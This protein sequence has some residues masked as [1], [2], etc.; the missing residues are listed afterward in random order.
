MEIIVIAD[1]SIAEI[2]E[3]LECVAEAQEFRGAS[4]EDILPKC[5]DYAEYLKSGWCYLWYDSDTL[6]P[7]GYTLFVFEKRKERFP[8][9]LMGGTRF[10]K[11]RHILKIRRAMLNVMRLEFKNQVRAYIDTDRIAKFAIANGFKKLKKGDCFYG[12][13]QYPRYARS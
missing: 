13:V 9:F 5:P 11:T 3:M 7:L 8:M 10:C 2:R 1:P 4:M 12:K 6:R